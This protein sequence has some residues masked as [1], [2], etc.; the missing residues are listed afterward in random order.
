M[1]PWELYRKLESII[2]SVKRKNKLAYVYIRSWPEYYSIICITEVG[3]GRTQAKAKW[4]KNPIVIDNNR[5]I[6]RHQFPMNLYE[7]NPLRFIFID[8]NLRLLSNW[9]WGIFCL[10][11]SQASESLDKKNHW[12]SA[13][14]KQYLLHNSIFSVRVIFCC[15]WNSRSGKNHL[16]VKMFFDSRPFTLDPRPFNLDPRL[17]TVTVEPRPKGKLELYDTKSNY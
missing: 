15:N 4:E 12:V 10:I 7:S 5:W 6:S 17:V 9:Y 3:N 11:F 1:T 16:A 2:L 14:N 13:L 8:I